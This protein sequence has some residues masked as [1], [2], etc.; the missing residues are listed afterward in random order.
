MNNKQKVAQ[1][2]EEIHSSLNKLVGKKCILLDAPYYHNIGD[3]LIWTGEQCYLADNNIKC[4]YTAS[5]ETCTFPKIDE[6]VTILF[7]G[8]GNLG[9]I[10]HEH[11]EFLLSVVKHYPQNR[12]VVLPQTVYYKDALLE[13]QDF[14]ALSKHKDLYFC[15]RD[16]IVYQNLKTI[17]GSHALVLP[18]MAFCISPNRLN[19]YKK[20]ETKE[21]LIIDREDCE[22]GESKVGNDGEVSDWPVFMHSFRKSTFVNKLFKRTAD[23]KIPLMTSLSNKVW[24]WYA[25][26]FFNELMI[27]EG[28]EFI[29][30]YKYVETARLHGCILSILLN[31]QITLVN[32]SYGKNKNFYESWLSDLETIKLK[33]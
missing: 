16:Y 8:G 18:D 11:M 25:C 10:Y 31:K 20:S 19:P 9:D 12:I 21:K 23:A 30:P 4:L 27:K 1:L 33:S 32:N 5:Y 13:A 24:N 29:S 26:R 14:K 22:R 15:C 6:D 3:V 28:V 7:N 2:R 17:F